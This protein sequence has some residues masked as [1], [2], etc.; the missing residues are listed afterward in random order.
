MKLIQ[1]AIFIENAPGRVAEVCGTL[2]KAGINIRA[3][4][5]GDG[6]D[7]GVLRIVAN[8]P[9]KAKEA[10]KKE[11]FTVVDTEVVAVEIPDK[12]GG[13]A[14]VLDMLGKKAVNVEYMYVLVTSAKGG[15]Y[16]IFRFNDNDSAIK[17]LQENGVRILKGEELYNL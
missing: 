8:D 11:G 10:L 7:Y 12:P 17:T 2:G 4:S 13:L 1:N 15:A 16:V 6:A 3:L 5:M 9:A 14:G